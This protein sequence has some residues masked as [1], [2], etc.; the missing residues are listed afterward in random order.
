[1]HQTTHDTSAFESQLVELKK[2]ISLHDEWIGSLID[3]IMENKRPHS[4][5]GEQ[6]RSIKR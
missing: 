4:R 2:Q 5:R 1:M 3:Y 6:G